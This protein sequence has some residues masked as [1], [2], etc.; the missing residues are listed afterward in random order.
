MKYINQYAELLIKTGLN[1]QKGQTLVIS[2]PVDQAEFARKCAKI[3]YETGAREV[4]M[5]WNDSKINR[6]YFDHADDSCF[7]EVQQWAVEFSN[8]Y[9]E[10]DA[11]YLSIDSSDPEIMKGVEPEKFSRVSKAYAKPLKAYRNRMMANK[12]AW[13][14]AALPNLAWAK[15]VFPEL[16]ETDGM[17]ALWNAIFMA[18][19]ADQPDPVAAWSEHQKNLDEKLNILNTHKFEHLIYKNSIGTNVTVGL[20]EGHIWYGGADTHIPKGYKFVANMPTEE[21]FTLP[22]R[23]KVNG[24]IVSSFPLNHDGNLIKDFWFEFKEGLVVDYGASENKDLL[25]AILEQ[26]PESKMLGEVALVPFDSPIS[27]LGLLFYNTLFDENAACH[28][29]LGEAYS[30]CIEGGE[31][32][33]EDQLKAKG[34]NCS[35]THVDFMVGTKD[36]EILGVTKDGEEVQIFK[37]GNFAI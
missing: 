31:D 12:N 26:D 11:A 18:T 1:I 10:L 5:K 34:A 36:L 3:A 33:S 21:V 32:M 35:M 2:S 23:E 19:R 8:H 14:L 13:C 20:P 17:E 4:V 16:S 9:G 30:V 7:D 25:T 29:A 37:N 22:H 27:N 28:F 6:L 15:K 24:K